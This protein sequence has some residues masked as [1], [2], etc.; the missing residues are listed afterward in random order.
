M[1]QLD[2][3]RTLKALEERL[4]DPMIRGRPEEVGDLLEDGFMEIGSSGRVFSKGEML[5]ALHAVPGFDG[6]RSIRDFEAK[7]LSDE[8]ILVV[9]RVPES[10][11]MRSSIWRRTEERWRMVFHQGTP[12]ASSHT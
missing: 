12:L 8:L 2:T 1:S 3:T 4:L 5:E 6:P 10:A 11:T 7:A 9:Y